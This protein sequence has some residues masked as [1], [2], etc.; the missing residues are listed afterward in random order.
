MESKH[1]PLYVVKLT[2]DFFGKKNNID[3]K[4][5]HDFEKANQILRRTV[6]QTYESDE[7]GLAISKPNIYD[8]DAAPDSKTHKWSIVS[9]RNRQRHITIQIFVREVECDKNC[10]T[11]F[12]CTWDFACRLRR[13][14]VHNEFVCRY[15]LKMS[16]IALDIINE[17]R[18]KEGLEI[19]G[20]NKFYKDRPMT[21]Q[22]IKEIAISDE[23]FKRSI[24]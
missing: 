14:E 20:Q 24:I 17:S 5:T 18:A 3:I 21:E 22:E 8:V 7:V 12:H 4:V 1:K 9:R 23:K 10:G 15:H 16:D 13:K 6:L 2:K 11:C 19:Y